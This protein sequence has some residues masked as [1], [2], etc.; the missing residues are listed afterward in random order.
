MWEG[1]EGWET[2]VTDFKV[3]DQS[4]HEAQTCEKGLKFNEAN[5]LRLKLTGTK[6]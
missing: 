3:P 6:S 5:L 1:A 2:P 4:V